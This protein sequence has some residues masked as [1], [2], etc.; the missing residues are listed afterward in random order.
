MTLKYLPVGKIFN[1]TIIEM[2]GGILK[3]YGEGVPEGVITRYQMT[4][5]ILP[6]GHSR[7]KLVAQLADMGNCS[8]HTALVVPTGHRT[9]RRR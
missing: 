6:R 3:G 9:S 7:I 4:E 8:I 5:G 1:N 2:A